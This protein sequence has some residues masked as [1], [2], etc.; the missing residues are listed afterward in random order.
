MHQ[1]PSLGFTYNMLLRIPRT[2]PPPP[3][4]LS[5]LRAVV[6]LVAGVGVAVAH[7]PPADADVLDGVEVTPAGEAMAVWLMESQ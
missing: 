2:I 1:S 5:H 3:C 7:A 6:G 4:A